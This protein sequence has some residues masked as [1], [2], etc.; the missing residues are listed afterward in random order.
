MARLVLWSVMNNRLHPPFRDLELL[1]STD[2]QTPPPV[3]ARP[4]DHADFPRLGDSRF[5]F[6]MC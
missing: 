5:S 6:A 2:G 3:T 1:Q 4:L